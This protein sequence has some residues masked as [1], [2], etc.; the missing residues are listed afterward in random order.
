VHLEVGG[1]RL[2]GAVHS[3]V[4]AV[5]PAAA[6][7]SITLGLSAQPDLVIRADA[8]RL[9]QILGNVL[10]NALKFTPQDGR[11]DVGVSRHG[12]DAVIEVRDTG[13][14]IEPELLPYLFEPFRQGPQA[15]QR[16]RSGLGIG[17]AL[18]RY[19]TEKHGGSVAAA[20]QGS[21]QGAVFTLRFPLLEDVERAAAPA[22]TGLTTTRP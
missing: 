6:A 11:I 2:A 14:G 18:V 9:Q 15:S 17:L 3:A 13:M 10:G 22:A 12:G 1:D 19:L 20:S 21:E 4:E 5:R 7:K 8:D 16:S